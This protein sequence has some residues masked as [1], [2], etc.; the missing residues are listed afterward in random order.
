MCLPGSNWNSIGSVTWADDSAQWI[1]HYKPEQLF[2]L[3]EE[4]KLLEWWWHPAGSI[5]K[6]LIYEAFLW[7]LL[8]EPLSQYPVT[9]NLA[10][11]ISSI[12]NLPFHLDAF[13]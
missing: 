5:W 10:A 7:V 3:S 9:V 4:W 1:I 2:W 6:L 12:L 8:F 11:D 13:F